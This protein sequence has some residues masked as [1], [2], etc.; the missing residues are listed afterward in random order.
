MTLQAITAQESAVQAV[1]AHSQILKDAMD[2]SEVNWTNRDFK[3]IIYLLCSAKFF[4]SQLKL[5][6][7][8]AMALLLSQLIFPLVKCC[9]VE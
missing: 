4:I 1:N 7:F 9:V 3:K 2:N 5:E 8:L 6:A